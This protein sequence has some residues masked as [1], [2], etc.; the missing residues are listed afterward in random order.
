[1][2]TVQV[3]ILACDQIDQSLVEPE[4]KKQP[5][6]NNQQQEREDDE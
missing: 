2:G 1:L 6:Q 4:V 3:Q 5:P